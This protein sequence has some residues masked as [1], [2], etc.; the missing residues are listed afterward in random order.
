MA[1]SLR[2][3]SA[4]IRKDPLVLGQGRHKPH[5]LHP[6]Q[7]AMYEA[8]APV[9]PPVQTTVASYID[10]VLDKGGTSVGNVLVPVESTIFNVNGYG[11]V[12]LDNYK[13]PN[14]TPANSRPTSR[15]HGHSHAAQQTMQPEPQQTQQE[16]PS[17]AASP[18]PPTPMTIQVP[19]SSSQ[20]IL[21][22]PPT[23][24]PPNPSSSANSSSLSMASDSYFDHKDCICAS[25][26]FN[27]FL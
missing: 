26:E 3:S 4:T 10:V 11:P 18:S 14:P 6:R 8:A 13:L 19:G 12:T 2:T 20:V 27:N 21:S 25:R 22:S 1:E 23:P 7:L 24:L 16:G 9:V 5:R 15:R 17:A